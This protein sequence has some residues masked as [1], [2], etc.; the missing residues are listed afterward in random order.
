MSS[1]PQLKP[2]KR[3]GRTPYNPSAEER[4]KAA[5]TVAKMVLASIDQEVIARVLGISKDTLVKYYRR[6]LD[7]TYAIILG[8]VAGNVATVA[9]DQVDALSRAFS[10]V[11]PLIDMEGRFKALAS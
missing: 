6:E 10:M 2:P 11:S 9:R 1:A 4:A 5:S 3:I 8:E 7:T